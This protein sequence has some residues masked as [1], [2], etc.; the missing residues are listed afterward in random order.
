MNLLTRGNPKTEKGMKQ[1]YL[2][3]ILHLAPH[4]LSGYQVCALADGCQIP[5]LN[6]AGRGGMF[7]KGE[8]TNRIQQ[9]RIRKTKQFFQV[10]EWF[11]ARL[12]KEIQNGIKYALKHNLIPVF[13][14]NG[15]SDLPWEKFR[16]ILDGVEYRNI[17]QA[18]PQITFY[19]YTKI[20]GRKVPANYHLTFSRSAH[21]EL[22]VI[23]AISNQM[24]I[25]VVFDNKKLMPETFLGRKVINGDET[26]L[27]F[28]DQKNVIVGLKAKGPAKRD[29][30]GFVVRV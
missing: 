6:L 20:P 9:A 21:N 18:F 8:S 23:K 15:T 30:T 10:R 2:T 14:L 4:T 27:R 28:L 1:G 19:D 11:M 26:D 17:F 12:V 13:R 25:A 16:V 22:S 29:L 5:C 24:N 7:K 3:H